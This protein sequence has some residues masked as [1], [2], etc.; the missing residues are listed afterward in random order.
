MM[1]PS[2]KQWCMEPSYLEGRLVPTSLAIGHVIWEG[3]VH[4]EAGTVKR[5][6]DFRTALSICG[7]QGR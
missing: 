5:Q 7:H 3:H 4:Y 1:S 6:V 2:L